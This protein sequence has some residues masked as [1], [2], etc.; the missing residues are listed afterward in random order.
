MAAVPTTT[1]NAIDICYEV[2]E[3]GGDGPVAAATGDAETI[4]FVSGLGS[5]MIT[6]E[7]DFF[8]PLTDAGHRVVRFDNRDVGLTTKFA[9]TGGLDELLAAFGGEEIDPPYRL[10]DMARDAVGLLDA[11][12][13][14]RAHVVGSSMGGMIAQTFAIEHR[15]RLASLTSIMSTTGEPDVGAPSPEVVGVLLQPS[16]TERE[17]AIEH[18]VATHRAIG[19]PTL[20]DEDRARRKATEAYDRCFNPTGTLNQIMAIAASGDRAEGLA[21][22]DA[23]TLVVH[24]EADPLVGVSGG[25]RTAELVAG[26]ELHVHAEMG[27]DIPRPLWPDVIDAILRLVERA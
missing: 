7:P 23:P 3:P 24:G 18:A 21:A 25:R 15:D 19:S 22:L 2:Y 8:A 11:L 17:P 26:A 20:F 16:P 27:H 9:R 1:A 5:Q 12:G 6:W 14:D 13:I 4:L 10:S